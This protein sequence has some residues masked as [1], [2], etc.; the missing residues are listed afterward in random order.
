MRQISTIADL[1][2]AGADRFGSA[3]ALVGSKG[4]LTYVEM[5]A[6]AGQ[7]AL[8]L[9]RHIPADPSR[10]IA[11][12][13]AGKASLCL[14][15]YGIA[16]HGRSAMVCSEELIPEQL[17][18]ILEEYR[19]DG[20]IL[21]EGTVA[22]TS[23]S[24][25]GYEGWLFALA[26]SGALDL[27]AGPLPARAGEGA[28]T[29]SSA[30]DDEALVLFTSG[31]TGEKK[32][33]PISHRNLIETSL[34]INRFMGVDQPIT[35]LVTVPLSHAFGLR[36]IVC[37]HLIG[38]TAVVEDGP[39]NPALALRTLRDGACNGLSAV[40][41][42]LAVMKAA[43][44]PALREVG[45]RIEFI[46]LGSAPL[47]AQGKAELCGLFP[48]AQ[49]CM[50]YGLTEASKVTFLH[51]SRDAHKLHTIGKPSPGIEVKLAD[52]SGLETSRGSVGEVWARGFSVATGYLQDGVLTRERFVDGWFRTGDLARMD[53]EGY[54]ELVGRVDDLINVGGKKLY[55]LEV[56]QRLKDAFPEIDCAVG[57]EEH[58]LLGVKPVLYYSQTTPVSA[59]LF[60]DMVSRLAA[61]VEPYK[62]PVRAVSVPAIPRTGNG[63]ILRRDLVRTSRPA[64][65]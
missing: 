56:E 2:E 11:V 17:R 49:L 42:V 15:F 50:H 8:T 5:A 43:F 63:K 22:R 62:I 13:V 10:R 38:G 54:L 37:D 60:R 32:A 1:L 64:A 23:G 46:E 35:E 6:R 26:P 27:I 52:D 40:P 21:D 33:V 18:R 51:F 29:G 24:L 53:A 14:A 57:A 7:I 47:S 4:S 55:P 28:A 30:P 58:E 12:H 36:R 20:M 9:D 65:S 45:P 48:K 44:A 59:A 3:P 16:G 39:F 34:M 25:A 61:C 19:P 41:G 31:T